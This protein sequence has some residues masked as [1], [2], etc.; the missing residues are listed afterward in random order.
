MKKTS[1]RKLAFLVIFCFSLLLIF[2]QEILELFVYHKLKGLSANWLQN[3]ME[4]RAFELSDKGFVMKGIKTKYP[5]SKEHP[6]S[7]EGN[8]EVQYRFS[9]LKRS[10][11]LDVNLSQAQFKVLSCPQLIHPFKNKTLQLGQNLIRL[12]PSIQVKEAQLTLLQEG[13]KL[14]TF[15]LVLSQKQRYAN[16]FELR[17]EQSSNKQS[18]NIVFEDRGDRSGINFHS[19][20]FPLSC[21]KSLTQLHEASANLPIFSQ[22]EQGE[23]SLSGQLQW[24]SGGH[25]KINRL[26]GDIGKLSLKDSQQRWQAYLDQLSIGI[27]SK[28]FMTWESEQTTLTSFSQQLIDNLQY[29][30]VLGQSNSFQLLDKNESFL[31]LKDLLFSLQKTKGGD[32]AF[33]LNTNLDNASEVLALQT[34]GK[35]FQDKQKVW[36]I[37]GDARKEGSHLLS[38]SLQSK[39]A[40]QVAVETQFQG[41][42]VSVWNFLTRNF[43]GYRNLFTLQS[44]QVSGKLLALLDGLSLSR[45]VCEKLSFEKLHLKSKE[46]L[47][48]C[49]ALELDL[50]WDCYADPNRQLQLNSHFHGGEFF[51]NSLSSDVLQLNQVKGNVSLLEGDVSHLNLSF[52]VDGLESKILWD[53]SVVNHPLNLSVTGKVQDIVK[54]IEPQK[55]LE[56]MFEQAYLDSDFYLSVKGLRNSQDFRLKGKLALEKKEYLQSPIVFESVLKDTKESFKLVDLEELL[57]YS[58]LKKRSLD[59]LLSKGPLFGYLF[60]RLDF[61]SHGVDLSSFVSPYILDKE[62]NMLMTGKGRVKGLLKDKGLLLSYDCRD[63]EFKADSFTITSPFVGEDSSSGQF[64][65]AKHYFDLVKGVHHGY[66][67]LKN[68]TYQDKKFGLCFEQAQA[69]VY[70]YEKKLFFSEASCQFDGVEFLGKLELD[71]SPYQGAFLK[72]FPEKVEGKL[73]DAKRFLSKVID[74]KPEQYDLKGYFNLLSESR[75]DFLFTKQ[76]DFFDF[77]LKGEA[78][79]GSLHFKPKDL[80]IDDARISFEFD[81]L[82]SKL[83]L[84]ILSGNF[85]LSE[86]ARENSPFALSSTH[87]TFQ[88]IPDWDCIFDVNL[89]E[90]SHQKHAFVGKALPVSS[91]DGGV[92]HI[93]LELDKTKVGSIQ[94]R[95]EEFTIRDWEELLV[96]KASPR[97]AF[98]TLF[99]DIQSL[100]SLNLLPLGSDLPALLSSHPYKGEASGEIVYDKVANLFH[101]SFSSKSLEIASWK[102]QDFLLIGKAYSKRLMFTEMYLDKLFASLDLERIG[103]VVRVNHCKAFY[104]KSLAFEFKE[105]FYRQGEGLK[106]ENANAFCNLSALKKDFPDL[107]RHTLSKAI[108]DGQVHVKGAFDLILNEDQ[109]WAFHS[110]WKDLQTFLKFG[111][112]RVKGVSPF[113]LNYQPKSGVEVHNLSWQF[114]LKSKNEQLSDLA[115]KSLIYSP[116]DKNLYCT[117]FSFDLFPEHINILG[118]CFDKDQFPFSLDQ[119]H[120]LAKKLSLKENKVKAELA[121][122]L[123]N[124]NWNNLTLLFQD[125]YYSALGEIPVADF[126]VAKDSKHWQTQAKLTLGQEELVLRA[127]SNNLSLES[128]HISLSN[129]HRA[130][131]D[132]LLVFWEKSESEFNITEVQGAL[133]GVKAQLKKDQILSD[134]KELVLQGTAELDFTFL[135]AYL[136]DEVKKGMA[137]LGLGKGYTIEGEIFVPRSN[138]KNTVFKGSLKG[139]NF[140]FLDS[141]VGS[142]FAKLELKPGKIQVFET[143]AKDE[144]GDFYVDNITLALNEK[145]KW[146]LMIPLIKVENFFPKLFGAVSKSRRNQAMMISLAEVRGV[147]GTLGE[148]KSFQG[149]GVVEFQNVAKTFFFTPLLLIPGEIIARIGLDPNVISPHS[150]TIIFELG[151]GLVNIQEFRDVYSKGKRSRFYLAGDVPSYIDFDGNLNIRIKIEQNTLIFKALELTTITMK[152]RLNK[153]VYTVQKQKHKEVVKVDTQEA[154]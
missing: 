65:W 20:N 139:K 5:L 95:V 86:H 81:M 17:L 149:K 46:L 106:T 80:Y 28:T 42:E 126:I 45:V 104:D 113:H 89:A 145:E 83:G 151:D 120:E 7:L 26:E 124:G 123:K 18:L 152:G 96:F 102:S 43:P 121:A 53:Q 153:P 140:E 118:A 141:Q 62:D 11:E 38:F 82:S 36:H 112:Y 61:S 32:L 131:Q 103:E 133:S 129:S 22:V 59:F 74:I 13:G 48:T 64:Y 10:L 9:L 63:F 3:E 51:F 84:N 116:Q 111:D 8:L 119:L 14:H 90:N 75:F 25:L 67:P 137:P 58:E 2:T 56:G 98:D 93:Q 72:V 41:L 50:N 128:G 94:P 24:L 1:L 33:E 55:Y 87:L 107:L 47:A 12:Y 79:E 127:K 77:T 132:P 144:L 40:S 31:G 15:D 92:Y 52:I 71:L 29:L 100:V 57:D 68:A 54:K 108:P 88:N 135:S 91:E 16:D 105:G 99:N 130:Q 142:L 146:D 101:F 134:E 35:V 117:G 60:E 109:A 148:D 125:G 6:V 23:L 44:G 73:E 66:L 34:S 143:F 115:L 37:K 97:V 70:L 85:A 30:K 154:A 110:S 4:Y 39:L 78:R 150:G 69:N 147:R 76:K 19:Q 136:P 49:E 138:L 27:I 114:F 21:V 122:H